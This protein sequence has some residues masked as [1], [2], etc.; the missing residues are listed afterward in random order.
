MNEALKL[1]ESNKV[2]KKIL[3]KVYEKYKSYGKVTGSFSLKPKDEEERRVLSNFDPSV[4]YK[5]LAKIKCSDVEAL[6]AKKFEG[7]S[8]SELLEKVVEEELKTNK[9]IKEDEE[10]RLNLFFKEII[11]RSKDGEGIKWFKALVLNKSYGYNNLIRKYNE[12]IDSYEG[13]IKDMVFVIE[14]LNNL[15]SLKNNYKNISVF[16]AEITKDPHFLDKKTFTGNIFKLALEFI[17]KKEKVKSL[18]EI[19]ELYYEAGILKDELSNHCTIY[20]LEAF[21]FR[22]KEIQAIKEFN[23]WEEPLEI[24]ISNLTKVNYIEAIKNEVYIFENPAVFHEVL[25]R[26]SNKVSLICTSG[27]VNLSSYILLDKIKNLKTIYY[28]GDFDSEGLLIA[29]KIKRRYKD[30]VKFMFYNEDIYKSILSDKFISDSRL[31]S[32]NKIEDT[33]LSELA[34]SISEEKRAAYEELLI[35]KYLQYME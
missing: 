34:K 26:S 22:N 15:P 3:K 9:E 7:I 21:D 10:K 8:F 12:S 4:I 1:I 14:A 13:L 31:A 11:D 2:Y 32:L 5:P 6:F 20:A 19:N 23:L 27:Q 30:K 28:G 24:S 33:E 25:K 16:A 29:D 17:Y 35:N 18:D